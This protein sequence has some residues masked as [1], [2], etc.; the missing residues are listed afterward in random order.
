MGS[1]SLFS[2][3]TLLFVAFRQ[4]ITSLLNPIKS[5]SGYLWLISFI[6]GMKF[7]FILWCDVS[8]KNDLPAL[9]CTWIFFA[10]GFSPNTRIGKFCGVDT[11]VIWLP[12]VIDLDHFNLWA[13]NWTVAHPISSVRSHLYRKIS[14]R[15]R[16]SSRLENTHWLTAFSLNSFEFCDLKK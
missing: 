11:Q 16:R 13:A 6:I 2:T 1:L 12:K 4:L 14:K 10:R 7:H 8:K 9:F 15:F 5:K 3:Q